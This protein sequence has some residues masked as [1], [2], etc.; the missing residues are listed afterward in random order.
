MNTIQIIVIAFSLIFLSILIYLKNKKNTTSA[1]PPTSMISIFFFSLIVFSCIL[2]PSKVVRAD[3]FMVGMYNPVKSTITVNINKTNY[4]KGEIITV[5]GKI[6]YPYVG[7]TPGI[8]TYDFKA[9]V[10]TST[11]TFPGFPTYYLNTL[12]TLSFI[13]PSTPGSYNIDYSVDM[14][15][16]PGARFDANV[17][18]CYNPSKDVTRSNDQGNF[19][20][21]VRTLDCTFSPDH[22]QSGDQLYIRGDHCG[23]SATYYPILEH[24]YNSSIKDFYFNKMV[25]D[26]NASKENCRHPA[27]TPK[28]ENSLFASHVNGTNTIKLRSQYADNLYCFDGPTKAYPDKNNYTHDTSFTVKPDPTVTVKVNGVP[29]ATDISYNGDAAVT[30]N[31]TGVTSCTCSCEDS[32][33]T[34]INC[35]NTG[36]KT[37]GT[38][39]GGTSQSPIKSTPVKIQGVTADTVFRVHCD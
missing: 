29:S 20:T 13:A 34:K 6:A 27:L 7:G 26:F 36:V 11:K 18:Y 12:Q 35:G 9:K 33:G 39:F 19:G 37:C 8:P 28:P 25:T 23:G 15:C 30:W 32:F 2:I 17:G 16:D 4:Q 3:T 10:G 5:T 31:S 22:W 1:I 24:R 21:G 14:Y 38:G